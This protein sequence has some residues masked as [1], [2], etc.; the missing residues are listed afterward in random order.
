MTMHLTLDMYIPVPSTNSVN[1]LSVSN[2]QLICRNLY[3]FQHLVFIYTKQV[4]RYILTPGSISIIT[5]KVEIFCGHLHVTIYLVCLCSPALSTCFLANSIK[6]YY[7]QYS[8]SSSSYI[9]MHL[10]LTNKCPH[11]YSCANTNM[12][13]GVIGL[14]HTAMVTAQMISLNRLKQNHVLPLQ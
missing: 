12:I 14:V 5:E 2:V 3:T 13:R 6:H 4:Y 1:L 7:I 10:T 8:S 11:E 9:H